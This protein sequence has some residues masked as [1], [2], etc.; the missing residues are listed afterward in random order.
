MTRVQYTE[1]EREIF[2]RIS[3]NFSHYRIYNNAPE[4]LKNENGIITIEKLAEEIGVSVSLLANMNAKNVEQ[5]ISIVVLN[6]IAK[7]LN[8]ALFCF[9]QEKQNK[10]PPA[11]NEE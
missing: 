5:T 1:E 11:Y 6:K 2:K 7:A 9:F 4:E 3:K 8:V 10:I